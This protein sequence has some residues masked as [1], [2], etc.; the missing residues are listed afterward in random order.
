MTL[1]WRRVSHRH[2]CIKSRFDAT[3]SDPAVCHFN[4]ETLFMRL[5]LITE[6]TVDFV[7][8]L[9]SIDVC[10]RDGATL[11]LCRQAFLYC[12]FS[13]PVENVSA[14]VSHGS[15]GLVLLRAEQNFATLALSVC[16]EGGVFSAWNFTGRSASRVGAV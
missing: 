16:S 8:S 11:N 7:L 5:M 1:K 15:G 10:Y 3:E 6:G 2:S 14:K 13:D 12:W 9:V 4:C